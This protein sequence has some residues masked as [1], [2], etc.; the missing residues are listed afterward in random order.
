MINNKADVL[1]YLKALKD[2]LL[3]E[4]DAGGVKERIKN[5]DEVIDFLSAQDELKDKE[6]ILLS[7][8]CYGCSRKKSCERDFDIKCKICKKRFEDADAFYSFVLME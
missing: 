6:S 8:S 3:C 4:A 7:L 1:D 5:L 2:E